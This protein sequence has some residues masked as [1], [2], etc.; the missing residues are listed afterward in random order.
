VGRGNQAGGMRHQR[1]RV[2]DEPPFPG[3]VLGDAAAPPEEIREGVRRLR[4]VLS[5]RR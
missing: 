5:G 4:A 2:L 3:L 1:Q